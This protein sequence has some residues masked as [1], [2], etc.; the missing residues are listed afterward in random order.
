[1]ATT[2]QIAELLKINYQTATRLTK[3]FGF[4][5]TDS[6]I[7]QPP[8]VPGMWVKKRMVHQKFYII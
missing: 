6:L 2:A 3:I 8:D 1:M 4:E 5:K 7:E